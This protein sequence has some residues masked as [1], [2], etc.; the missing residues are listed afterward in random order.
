MR[1]L[2][3]IRNEISNGGAR[4]ESA[5]NNTTVG[6]YEKCGCDKCL[7]A[8]HD[9]AKCFPIHRLM[10]D[11]QCEEFADSLDDGGTDWQEYIMRTP[12]Y[13]AHYVLLNGQALMDDLHLEDDPM[14]VA[15]ADVTLYFLSKI[16]QDTDD[17]DDDD[18]DD[19]EGDQDAADAWKEQQ[20]CDELDE[21]EKA[22]DKK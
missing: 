6:E 16:E 20:W 12:H 10:T 17:D 3:E 4:I 8:M 5:D 19:L 2:R 13:P 18:D 9:Y 1:N 11:E 15:D 14:T 7:A 22:A 21:A